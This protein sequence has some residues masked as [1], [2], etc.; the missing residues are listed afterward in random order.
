MAEF[1]PVHIERDNFTLRPLFWEALGR[2]QYQSRR[3]SVRSTPT[4]WVVAESQVWE[5][6]SLGQMSSL[7]RRRY[8]KDF[9]KAMEIG[10]KWIGEL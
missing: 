2:P 4:G 1:P 3:G 7:I 9:A 6:R 8:V 5:S 10:E